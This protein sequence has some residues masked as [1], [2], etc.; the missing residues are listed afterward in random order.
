[1]LKILKISVLYILKF[2]VNLIFMYLLRFL[3]VALA[4]VGLNVI[5][6]ADVALT[7]LFVTAKIQLAAPI[8]KILLK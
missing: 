4:E 6:Y 1:L 8:F 2:K 5:V 7:I 3:A